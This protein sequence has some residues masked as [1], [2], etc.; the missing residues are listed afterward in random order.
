M[1]P[2]ALDLGAAPADALTSFARAEGEL[3]VFSEHSLDQTLAREANGD[4]LLAF[5][6]D[7][8]DEDR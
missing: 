8:R 7:Y 5:W 6:R 3:V 1:V 2:E 4:T